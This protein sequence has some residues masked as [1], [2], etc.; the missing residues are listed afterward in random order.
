MNQ[1]LLGQRDLHYTPQSHNSDPE[2]SH[3]AEAEHRRSGRM[4]SNRDFV[5]ATVREHPG[6][7]SAELAAKCGRL[8]DDHLTEVRRRLTGLLNEGAV[9]QGR[10]RTCRVKGVAMVTWWMV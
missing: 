5:L 8:C 9:T 6:C 2:S 7:T 3:A 1:R 4:W 10:L